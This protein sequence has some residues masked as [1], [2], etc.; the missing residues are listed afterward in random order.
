[1]P[2]MAVCVAPWCA[3]ELFVV[4]AESLADVCSCAHYYWYHCT[5]VLLLLEGLHILT[6][7]I[8]IIIIN[9]VVVVAVDLITLLSNYL[10][11]NLHLS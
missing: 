11:R 8:N 6:F 1:M 9:V 4:F 2:S 7:I 3:E 5:C 10:L